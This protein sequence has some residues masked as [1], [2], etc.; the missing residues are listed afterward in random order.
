[1]AAR[2]DLHFLNMTPESSLCGTSAALLATATTQETGTRPA[3]AP[4]EHP[5][6]SKRYVITTPQ[7]EAL[8]SEAVNLVENRSPGAVIWAPPRTGKSRALEILQLEF[9]EVFPGLPV[10][11]LPAWDYTTPR[12]GPF[13]E[14]LLK[15]AGHAIVKNGRAED[16]RE[17]LVELMADLAIDKGEGRIVLIVDEAQHLHEKHYKWLMGIHNLLAMYGVHMITLLVGQHQLVHQRTAFLRGQKE[18]IVGRFMVQMFQFHG[19]QDQTELAESLKAYDEEEYPLGSGWSYTR[20][21]APE[22]CATGWRL[23]MVAPLLWGAFYEARRLAPAN[24]VPKEIQ[25]QYFCRA[26][27]YLLLNIEG[28]DVQN[29]EVMRKLMKTAIAASRYLDVLVIDAES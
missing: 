27:E 26:V 9:G 3:I 19:I 5:I 12:E 15:A 16:K 13:M 25:M 14:D 21:F 17:R 7:V 24:K 20:F 29:D 4:G 6:R 11:L 1:M 8:C 23:T 22:L 2:P 18:N 28:V 10:M